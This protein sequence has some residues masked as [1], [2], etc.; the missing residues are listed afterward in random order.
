MGLILFP[1]ISQQL[2]S[3]LASFHFSFREVFEFEFFSDCFVLHRLVRK[4]SI[5]SISPEVRW[6]F[7]V[8]FSITI[9]RDS[10]TLIF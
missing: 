7:L 8:N 5:G 6:K 3:L 10:K 1:G 4:A 9:L 2:H